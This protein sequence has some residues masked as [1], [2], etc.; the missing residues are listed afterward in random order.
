METL[1]FRFIYTNTSTHGLSKYLMILVVVDVVVVA[2]VVD[3][4]DGVWFQTT[5]SWTV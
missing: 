3:V 1:S 2:V 4:V 5:R